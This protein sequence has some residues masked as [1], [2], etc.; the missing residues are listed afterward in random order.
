MVAESQV[1][2]KAEPEAV[3]GAEAEAEVQ[4]PRRRRVSK[5]VKKTKTIISRPKINIR[6]SSSDSVHI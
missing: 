4:R 6:R 3:P 2:A 5:N 1:E